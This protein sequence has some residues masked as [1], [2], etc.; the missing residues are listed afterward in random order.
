MR[1]TFLAPH[2]SGKQSDHSYR[3]RRGAKPLFCHSAPEPGHSCQV[4]ADATTAD[5][6]ADTGDPNAAGA[7]LHRS[8]LSRTGTASMP[9]RETGPNRSGYS[10]LV[11]F[12]RP[13][14]GPDWRQNRDFGRQRPRDPRRQTQRR[15]KPDSNISSLSGSVPLR[16]GGAV[17]VA[18]EGSFSVAGPIVRIHLPPAG[19][20]TNPTLRGD[21]AEPTWRSLG[22]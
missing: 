21:A 6:P 1:A 3:F 12:S 15:R 20:H 18:P 11:P 9:V 5:L 16:A 7:W 4:R 10:Q 17:R 14:P 13:E 2:L 19:S 22:S 8:E